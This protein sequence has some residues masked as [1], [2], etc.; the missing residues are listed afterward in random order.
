MFWSATVGNEE[1]VAVAKKAKK[2]RVKITVRRWSKKVTDTSDAM[3]LDDGV[4][5]KTPRA[6][7]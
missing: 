4:F 5:K 3:T 1:Y 2:G 7:A 6:I